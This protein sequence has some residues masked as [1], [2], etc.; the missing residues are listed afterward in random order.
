M[1]YFIFQ[2]IPDEHVPI[3]VTDADQAYFK[4]DGDFCVE[5]NEESKMFEVE[6][7]L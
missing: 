4:K 1:N 3:S 7:I 6:V 5:A 2:L